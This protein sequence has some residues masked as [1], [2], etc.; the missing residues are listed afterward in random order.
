VGDKK[1]IEIYPNLDGRDSESSSPNSAKVDTICSTLAQI[2]TDVRDILSAQRAMK[3]GGISHMGPAYN[4]NGF[5]AGG[6]WAWG[7]A[8]G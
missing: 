8:T 2:G 1:S 6:K 4:R 5:Y 3:A 7:E